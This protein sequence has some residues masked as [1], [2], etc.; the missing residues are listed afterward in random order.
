MIGLWL[1]KLSLSAGMVMAHSVVDPLHADT[2]A[3]P[4]HH[5][6][7]AKATPALLP[8]CH[9]PSTAQAKPARDDA[10]LGPESSDLTHCT[11][12]SDCHH[13][14]PLAWG[15][16]AGIG[17]QAVPAMRPARQVPDW[18]SASWLPGLRPPKA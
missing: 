10:Q 8:D 4:S 1:L 14:C 18:H 13:C 17:M 11:A 5:T 3:H 12:H 2:S 15:S 6:E 9:G 16:W 7:H